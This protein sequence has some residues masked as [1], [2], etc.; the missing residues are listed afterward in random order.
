[1]LCLAVPLNHTLLCH[2]KGVLF[3]RNT[4]LDLSYHVVVLLQHS[5]TKCCISAT[6]WILLYFCNTTRSSG[7]L[8]LIGPLPACQPLKVFEPLWTPWRLWVSLTPLNL[9]EAR[10]SLWARWTDRTPG[11]LMPDSRGS[12]MECSQICQLIARRYSVNLVA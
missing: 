11:N 7:S 3:L 10:W 2:E 12:V 5:Q 6:S 1:M 4:P 9:I 8:N